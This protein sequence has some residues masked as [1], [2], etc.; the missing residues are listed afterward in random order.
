MI[1]QYLRF[2]TLTS[3]IVFKISTIF[4]KI[5]KLFQKNR[6][7]CSPSIHHARCFNKNNT[8][9]TAGTPAEFM[10]SLEA[11]EC[12]LAKMWAQIGDLG[13]SLIEV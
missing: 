8:G 4:V 5:I 7:I 12:E 1:A 10:P 11:R 3:L 2:Y 13:Q 9:H 6:V